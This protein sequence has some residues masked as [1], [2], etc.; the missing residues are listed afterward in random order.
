M[1]NTLFMETA[2]K[3]LIK[4]TTHK[5]ANICVCHLNVEKQQ[6][7]FNREGLNKKYNPNAILWI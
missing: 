3:T 6:S 2:L 7:T 1:N 5:P 4:L